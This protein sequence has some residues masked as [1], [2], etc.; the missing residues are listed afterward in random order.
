M[1]AVDYFTKMSVPAKPRALTSDDY[2]EVGMREH[3]KAWRKWWQR[4][5]RDYGAEPPASLD[6][7]P[8]EV[9]ALNAPA[10]SRMATMATAPLPTHAGSR[11][12][13]KSVAI[14]SVLAALLLWAA[15]RKGKA[16]TGD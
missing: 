10:L 7:T 5:A 4:R 9:A 3:Y 2:N 8:E 14:L 11:W 12:I 1:F 6:A 15:L 13:A 16:K